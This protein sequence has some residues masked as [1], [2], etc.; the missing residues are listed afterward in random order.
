MGLQ[1]NLG[2]QLLLYLLVVCK[3]CCGGLEQRARG[4]R[5]ASYLAFVLLLKF[6]EELIWHSLVHAL[7]LPDR[8]LDR[9]LPLE[10]H[11]S[12]LRFLALGLAVALNTAEPG[13]QVLLVLAN[14]GQLGPQWHR[15]LLR[16]GS[17]SLG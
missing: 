10:W 1:L 9:G 12:D 5:G 16:L 2:R 14:R 17:L 8:G 4:G 7:L 15:L 11:G 6:Q 3:S 13:S